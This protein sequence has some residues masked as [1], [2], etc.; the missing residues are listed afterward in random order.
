MP[1]LVA[2]LYTAEVSTESC[3]VFL[4]INGFLPISNGF[5]HLLKEHPDEVREKLWQKLDNMIRKTVV[6]HRPTAIRE[7]GGD[8]WLITFPNADDAV[9]WALRIKRSVGKELMRIIVGID[10]GVPRL[11]KGGATDHASIMAYKIVESMRNTQSNQILV[12]KKVV[13]RLSNRF[14]V[15][16]CKFAGNYHVPFLGK[17]CLYKVENT[18]KARITC[19]RMRARRS[20][21]SS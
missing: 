10:W 8:S 12:T 16:L 5:A 4:D 17:A 15:R 2:S 20:H 1:N 7:V 14:L 9:E 6:R 13:K 21:V 19:R 18:S 11:T 3:I